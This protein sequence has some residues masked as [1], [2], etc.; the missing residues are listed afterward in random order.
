[1]NILIVD[2]EK[3]IRDSLRRYLSHSGLQGLTA[4]NGFAAQRLLES[5]PVH[6]I[7]LDL[8]MPE[9]D[10]LAFIKWVREQGYTMPILMISAHGEISDAVK[11]IKLG[12]QDY[13]EKPFN[14]D[15][16]VM[17]LKTLLQAAQYRKLGEHKVSTDTF[18]GTSPAIMNIK[19][20]IDQVADTPSTV[21]ITGE[22]GTGKEVVARELHRL[23]P[24]SEHPF[25]AINIG[26]IPESLLES[27]L[28]GYEKGAFTGAAERKMGLFEL[29]SGGTL[30]LDEIGDM[31]MA[32]QVKILR[33]LQERKITRLGGTSLIPIDVRVVAATNKHLEK[34]V[35][36][37]VFREDL[38]YRL[39]VVRVEMPPLRDHRE[40]IPD[41]VDCFLAKYRRAMGKQVEGVAEDAMQFLTT[42]GYPGNIRE[43]ENFIERGVIFAQEGMV[44]L[45]NLAVSVGKQEKPALPRQRTLKAMERDAIIVALNRWEGSRTKAAEELG[46]SRRTII[47]KIQEYGIEA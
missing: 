12:A 34:Q 26:G 46:V 32:L 22:S 14:P 47:N 15:S 2:D 13:M 44:E 37:G 17:R 33:V 41:L 7:V 23:S 38:F 20:L 6:A 5:E 29:A 18:I 9:M 28:F 11:A 35:Q 1:M 42:Y 27:E 43:L 8:K 25:M 45:D 4:G 24:R 36:E 40:D 3:N 19:A 10:G 31:P 30:F 39:N 21:L 16:L